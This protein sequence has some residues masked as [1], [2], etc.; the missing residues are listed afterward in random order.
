MLPA[1]SVADGAA[2]ECNFGTV[3]YVSMPAGFQ[4]SYE[5]EAASYKLQATSYKLRVS[6]AARLRRRISALY[7]DCALQCS[8]VPLPAQGI[9]KCKSLL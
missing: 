5:L 4:D 7:C 8:P 9:I 1:F 6:Q 3:D 2:L